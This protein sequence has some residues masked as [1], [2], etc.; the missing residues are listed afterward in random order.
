MKALLACSCS[1]IKEKAERA[2]QILFPKTEMPEIY[3]GADAVRELAQKY[4]NTNFSKHL[5]AIAKTK[6]QW[7][8]LVETDDDGNI[9]EEHDLITGRRVG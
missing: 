2:Y 1:G 3:K 9:I 6:G 8:Y 4:P 5:S 7:A